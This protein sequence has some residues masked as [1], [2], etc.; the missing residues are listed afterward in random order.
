[1]LSHHSTAYWAGK[2]DAG[3]P[4]AV[5]SSESRDEV[6]SEAFKAG[7]KDYLV[8]PIRRRELS[9]LWHH[10][11]VSMERSKSATL[12]AAGVLRGL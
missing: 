4:A 8:K 3:Q 2:A 12:P 11:P 10:V 7:A 1:M 5:M 9:K 6:I